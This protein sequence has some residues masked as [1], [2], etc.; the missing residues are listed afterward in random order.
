MSSDCAPEG[1]PPFVCDSWPIFSSS[2]MR[3]RS[4]VIL[5]STSRFPNS[6]LSQTSACIFSPASFR[7]IVSP[8]FST[9]AK[10]SLAL[11]ELS[12]A[13]TP[14]LQTDARTHAAIADA[15][16]CDDSIFMEFPLLTSYYS[17]WRR[18]LHVYVRK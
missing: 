10:F 1:L 2:V 15:G 18:K 11:E 5:R 13:N 17:N 16:I 9:E 4:S 12:T 3:E 6:V 8:P 7:W 14:R